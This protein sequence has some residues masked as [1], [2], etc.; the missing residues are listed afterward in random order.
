MSAADTLYSARFIGPELIERD[1]ANL[2]KAPIYR[3]GALVAPASGTVSIYDSGGSAIVDAAAVT[4]SASVAQYSLASATVSAKNFGSGWRIEWS[5]AMPD[6]VTHT[7]RRSAALVRRALYPVITDTDLTELHSDLST[8]RPANL[9][10][11]QQY[12]DSA[13]HDII[14]MLIN[15]GNFPYLVMEPSAFRRVHLY[16]TIEIIS[17]DFSTSFGDGSK[18][19]G[20]ADVYEMKFDKS[21]GKLNFIYDSD[22]DGE[23]DSR[24]RPA[25]PVMWLGIGRGR[26]SIASTLRIGGDKWRR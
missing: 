6:S 5:L 19:D 25:S 9:T 12:I 2:L 15:A 11:Y 8:L 23:P 24:K 20:L 18:W 13:W 22:D 7:F 1:R 16:K 21:W 26:N 17:R 10:S 14:D 4:V 3:S